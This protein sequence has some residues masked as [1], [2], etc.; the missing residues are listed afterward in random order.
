MI[1]SP[2]P[3]L[4]TTCAHPHISVRDGVGVGEVRTSRHHACACTAAAQPARKWVQRLW[5]RGEHQTRCSRPPSARRQ[6]GWGLRRAG[7]RAHGGS[8]ATASLL[9]TCLWMSSPRLMQAARP[10]KLP[11]CVRASVCACVRACVC[12]CVCVCVCMCVRVCVHARMCV[13]V[14]ICACVQ[15]T[16]TQALTRERALVQFGRGSVVP[17]LCLCLSQPHLGSCCL[18]L[19][20]LKERLPPQWGLEAFG[21][22]QGLRGL[23]A[24]TKQVRLVRGLGLFFPSKTHAVVCVCVRVCECV[25]AN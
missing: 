21:P 7:G 18:C 5:P 2:S 6:T 23:S 15:N 4:I 16:V 24:R 13:F 8:A 3:L 1:T 20:P 25:H 10:S 14:C 9:C 19:R 17:E 11:A 22:H 12:V